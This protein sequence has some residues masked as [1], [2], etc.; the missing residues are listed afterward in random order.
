MTS[1]MGQT[2]LAD[3]VMLPDNFIPGEY[4]VICQR[5]ELL[6]LDILDAFLKMIQ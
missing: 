4:D 5:G 1:G 3:T 6:P 2:P